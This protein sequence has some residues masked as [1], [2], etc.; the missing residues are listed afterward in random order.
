MLSAK[1][2]EG[3]QKI[4]F[5]PDAENNQRAAGALASVDRAAKSTER[6]NRVLPTHPDRRLA[7][8]GTGRP[9]FSA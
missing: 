4:R 8:M 5:I 1:D 3:E 9:T 6:K 7:P 2:Y